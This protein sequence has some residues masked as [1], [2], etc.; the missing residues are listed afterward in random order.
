MS[1]KQLLQQSADRYQAMLGH[2]TEMAAILKTAHPEAIKR[3]LEEWNR[4]QGEARQLDEQIDLRDKAFAEG[5]ASQRRTELMAQVAVQC[6]QVYSQANLLKA[7]VSDELHSLN[8]G[9]QALGGY[10]GARDNKGSRLTAR[11]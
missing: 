6:R 1:Q 10:K 5:P 3:G 8:Q 4:L 11:S 2:L 9:R 7:L